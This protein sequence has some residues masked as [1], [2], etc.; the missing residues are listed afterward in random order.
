MGTNGALTGTATAS[1]TF[2]ST[3]NATNGVGSPATQSFT[4]TVDAAPH[5]TSANN[6]TLVLG[7]S[8]SFSATATGFPA[9]TFSD[10]GPLDGLSMGTNGALTGT[11]TASGAFTSTITATN[12]VGSPA[13][14]SFTLNVD[15]APHITSANATSFSQGA[16]GSFTVTA[17]GNP[18]PTFTE[19]GPL[20]SGVSLSTAGLL[21]GTP[22]FGTAG[23]YPITITAANGVGT[24]APRASP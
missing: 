5:I 3:I 17:T 14:Q 8:P 16:A 15:V 9:P 1:G 6:Y 11:A 18:A 2:A 22:A 7:N 4:L 23:S 12:G 19:T 10:P 21:S 20:P 24:R 13:T